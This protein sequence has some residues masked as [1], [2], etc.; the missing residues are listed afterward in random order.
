M[1]TCG[2]H[3]HYFSAHPPRVRVHPHKNTAEPLAP[4]TPCGCC[5]CGGFS[6]GC[7]CPPHPYASLPGR[8][9]SLIALITVEPLPHE[10]GAAAWHG[11]ADSRI[12]IQTRASL[13]RASTTLDCLRENHG[14]VPWAQTNQITLLIEADARKV[15]FWCETKNRNFVM[16]H[17]KLEPMTWERF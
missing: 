4:K 1:S 7:G 13:A 3:P 17:D 12:H 11:L 6:C 2:A 5:G 8:D 15:E 14:S 16:S 9:T 10:L